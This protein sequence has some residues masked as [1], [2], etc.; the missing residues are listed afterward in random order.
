[1]TAGER[2]H[3]LAGISG[4]AAALL[5]AIGAGATTGAALVDYSGLA[6][7]TAA[8]HLLAEHAPVV[9]A[10]PE[11]HGGGLRKDVSYDE[12]SRQ[13]ELLGLR[14]QP[15]TS[16][17]NPPVAPVAL[18]AET[19]APS[20]PVATF[21]VPLPMR[22]IPVL[23]HVD[24]ALAGMLAERD[25]AQQAAIHQRRRNEEYLLLLMLAEMD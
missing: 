5:L 11:Y 25:A 18:D 21:A 1:M 17:E 3:Q 24:A 4:T 12:V 16:N 8:E 23:P 2:L 20:A 6:T 10:Q 14:L 15:A 22:F 13:W 19:P 9:V 7:G